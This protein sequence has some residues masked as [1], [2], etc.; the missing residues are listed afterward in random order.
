[1]KILH[2][3]YDHPGNPWVGG[4]GSARVQ[5]LARSLA[6]RGHLIRLISGSYPGCS[7]ES[8]ERLSWEFIGSDRS[9]TASN[10]S[11][12][13]AARR[14]LPTL[15]KSF[16]LI[17]EDFAPW[18]PVGT[19]RPGTPPAI[20]QIQNFFGRNILRKFPLIGFPFLQI[21][22][23]Y[24]RKFRHAVVVNESINTS[25]GLQAEVIP[26]GVDEEWLKAPSNNDGYVA[27]LG[28]LDFAQKGLDLLLEAARHIDLPF[29]IA[30]DGPDR[31]KLIRAAERMQN[32]E[33]VGK[34]DSE[35]KKCFLQ[36]AMMVA[37]PS[38]FEGQ[39]MVS[40]EAA[41]LGKPLVVSDIAEL[42]FAADEGFGTS[43]PSG[44]AKALATTIQSLR[45]DSERREQ[46]GANARHYAARFTWPKI[47]DQFEC[48]CESVVA[49]GN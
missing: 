39:P 41:A 49:R 9:Y 32:V 48:Y 33:W 11:Y 37:L 35:A 34:L 16:D 10:F 25:L 42:R 13:L 46:N 7:A 5:I 21:E 6:D 19:H 8:S 3:I 20:L 30:G 14:M 1:M 4:G 2:F 47:A 38:R 15:A 27:F 40:L 31:D 45:D 28:R 12:A 44:D 43:F 26:M 36:N 18:N 24:P 22:K 23:R 29:R 17:I